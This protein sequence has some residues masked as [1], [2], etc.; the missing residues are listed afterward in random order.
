MSMDMASLIDEMGLPPPS[1]PGPEQTSALQ[2]PPEVLPERVERKRPWAVRGLDK[3]FARPPSRSPS[4]PPVMSPPALLS[5][6]RATLR[7]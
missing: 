3:D 2:E 1:S 7:T 5:P 6:R 4:P